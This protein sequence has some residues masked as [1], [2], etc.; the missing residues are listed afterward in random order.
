MEAEKAELERKIT[1]DE[2]S[3]SLKNTGNNIAPG[4]GGFSGAFYKVFWCY[5]KQEVLGT[6]HQV[7]ED[8]QLPVSL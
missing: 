3:K 8:K 7:F 5:L 4:A 6:I 2:I 1:L